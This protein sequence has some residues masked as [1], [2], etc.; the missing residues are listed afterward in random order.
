MGTLASHEYTLVSVGVRRLSSGLPLHCRLPAAQSAWS[1][2]SC[3]YRMKGRATD[4]AGA[5]S[6]SHSGPRRT[7][8]WSVLKRSALSRPLVG[9]RLVLPGV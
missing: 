2:A 3:H 1:A 9:H 6:L 5:S 7:L 8:S 4:P